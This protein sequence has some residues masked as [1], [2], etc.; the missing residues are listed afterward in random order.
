MRSERFGFAFGT[1]RGLS[2]GR[3]AYLP[4]APRAP[5]FT[6]PRPG[7]RTPVVRW[8]LVASLPSRGSLRYP[9]HGGVQDAPVL[10]PPSF[11]S[12]VQAVEVLGGHLDD[13]QRGYRPAQ[14]PERVG[15]AL[16]DEPI[17]SRAS[18]ARHHRYTAA[19]R[20]AYVFS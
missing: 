16:A 19:D 13:D 8:S 12:R 15:T 2:P 14:L 17:E 20:S 1:E 4:R 10:V 11:A 18:F 7:R 3:S 6:C 5:G 9:S